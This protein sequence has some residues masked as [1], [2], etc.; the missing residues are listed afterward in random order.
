MAVRDCIRKL[1]AAGYKVSDRDKRLLEQWVRDGLS[2]TQAVNRMLAMAE[3]DV[4]DIASRARDRGAE[5]RK[6]P[7]VLGEIREYRE[8]Q[9]KQ[10]RKD[11]AAVQKESREL[12]IQYGDIQWIK[13]TVKH[14]TPLN[15]D[16]ERGAPIVGAGPFEGMD[17]P[18]DLNDDLALQNRLS[19]M[20]FANPDMWTKGQMAGGL[21]RGNSPR[22]L[23]NNFRKMEEQQRKIRDRL[24][25]LRPQ[26]AA[27]VD[28]IDEMTGQRPN[29]FYQSTDLGFYSA[30]EVAVRTMPMPKGDAKTV[31]GW[32]QKQPGVTADEITWLQI[33]EYL[34][35]MENV[36]REELLDYVRANGVVVEEIQQGGGQQIQPSLDAQPA[37]YDFAAE[38]WEV[39]FDDVMDGRIEIWDVTE[40]E[41]GHVF[42]VLVDH[43]AGN[44]AVRNEQDGEFLPIDAPIN[45][46]DFDDAMAAIEKHYLGL[47]PAGTFDAPASINEDQ[48]L[49]GGRN[50]REII[51]KLPEV[52]EAQI[53]YTG[54]FKGAGMGSAELRN[55]VVQKALSRKIEMRLVEASDG[56]ER[57][58]FNGLLEK[59]VDWFMRAMGDYGLRFEFKREYSM[60]DAEVNPVGMQQNYDFSHFDYPN[61]MGWARVKDRIG[62]NGEKILFIEE[63]QSDL[64]QRGRKR[65]YREGIPPAP[66]FVVGQDEFQWIALD[67]K[68]GEQIY[69]GTNQS[70]QP[71]KMSVGKGAVADQF[72]AE[73]YLQRLIHGKHKEMVDAQIDAVPDAPFKN[74]KWVDLVLKRM[75]RLAAEQGYD[76]VAWTTGETQ[77]IRNSLATYADEV[78]YNW[79][80]E[81]LK[82]YSKDSEGRI[83]LNFSETVPRAKL[84]TYVGSEMAQMLETEQR[85]RFE[86]NL[87]RGTIQVMTGREYLEQTGGMIRFPE[88]DKGEPAAADIGQQLWGDPARPFL[89]A[90][91]VVQH[92]D[93]IQRNQ[94]MHDLMVFA[95][96]D[97]A[98]REAEHHFNYQYPVTLTGDDMQVKGWP[99][100]NFYDKTVP[101]QLRKIVKKLDRD[102]KVRL[103]GQ[104]VR[105][106][107]GEPFRLDTVLDHAR[108]KNTNGQWSRTTTKVPQYYILDRDGRRRAGPF[109]TSDVA[110]AKLDEYNGE[111]EI[112]HV[113]DLTNKI[114]NNVMNGQQLFQGKRGSITFN[115]AR[116][117]VIRLYESHNLST[118]IH[119]AGHLYLEIMG[120][121]ASRADS[122][123]QIK[124]DWQTI[125][126]YLGVDSYHEIT[127]EHHEKWAESFE[128]YTMEGKAPSIKLRDAFNAFRS[129]LLNVYRTIRGGPK[130]QVLTP[131]IRGVM[132]RM[133]ASDEEIAI[134]E[135]HQEYASLF[136]TQEESG[137]SPEAYAVYRNELVRAHNEGVEKEHQTVLQALKR[138]SMAWWKHEREKVRAE[139]E[140]EAHEMRVYKALFMLQRG[141]QPD[142]SAPTMSPFKINKQS[143]LDLLGPDQT[144]LNQLP[145]PWVYAAK[146]GVDV[147]EAARIFGYRDA[148]AM[149]NELASAPKMTDWIEAE[150]DVRMR[151]RYPD[152][153]HDGTLSETALKAVHN[154]RRANVLMTELRQ[155]RALQRRDR[156]IVR[157]TERRIAREER[158]AK[159]ANRGILPKRAELAAIK[160]GAKEAIG[161]RR[162]REVKPHIYLAA[163]RKAA[164]QAFEAATRK[165]WEAAYNFKRQQIINHEMYRAAV[166]AE[167]E[168]T[169][170]RNYLAKFEKPRKRQ[171]MGKAG[172]LDQIDAVLEGVDLRKKS[173]SQVDREERLKD[174]RDMVEDGRMIVTPETLAK[175]VDETVNWQQLTVEEMRGLRDVVK[176]L[177]HMAKQAEMNNY[178]VNGETLNLDDVA[179]ELEAS[180]LENNTEIALHGGHKTKKQ[181]V[182]KAKDQAITNWL[183]PSSI[184]RVL[185]KAGFGA[186]SRYIIVPLRRAYS[187]RLIPAL[188]KAQEDVSGIYLKHYSTK[189]LAK[190]HKKNITIESQGV[191]YSK[192][193]AIAVALNWGNEGN[194]RAL[195]GGVLDNGQLAYPEP[196]AR[197]LLAQLSE[198]DWAFVQDVWD[199]I[200]TYWK[201]LSE[202]EQ[203][204]RGIAPSKVEGQPFQIRTADGKQITVRGGYYPL[205]YD[206]EL[207]DR[208]KQDSLED[209]YKKLGT[210][211]YVSAS[212]R[213]G[214]THERTRQQGLVVRLDLNVID[215][216][217]REII[218]DIAIGDEVNFVKRILNDRRFRSA[219]KRTGNNEAL[220]SLNLWLTDAAVGE[221]PAQNIYQKGA[222]WIRGGF[223]KSRLG[224]NLLVT[225]LQWT[226]F[227]QSIAFVGTKGMMMG[228]GKF[229]QN[230]AKWW[231][232]VSESSDFIRTRYDVGAWHKDVQDVDA[233]LN[234]WFG[235]APTIAKETMTR[236]SYGLFLPIKYAQKVVDVITWLGAYEKARN[237]D[238]E[239]HQQSVLMADAAVEGAQTSGFFTDRSNIERGTLSENTRQAEYIRIWTTLIGYMLAKGNIAYEKTKNTNF[240]KPSQ[241]LYWSMDMILLFTVEGI[242]SYLLYGRLPEED[243][244]GDE[245][246]RWAK[247]TAAATADSIVSGI[248]FVREIPSQRYGSGSTPIGAFAKDL[249]NVWVQAEQGEAD[250]AL[251]KALVNAVGTATHLPSSQTNRVLDAI[252]D[253]D[254]TELLEYITGPKDD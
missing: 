21:L 173:L 40:R 189:D 53:L 222:R 48:T 199:Y 100:R 168:M 4:V 198:K 253:E 88:M 45:K 197:Q 226:G 103:N 124:D 143:L 24:R 43:D 59:D 154:E 31:L 215:I 74:N 151:Q 169:K 110:Q 42:E 216:H 157:A 127:R 68:T 206:H 210:G 14:W 241:I 87:E 81:E 89:D 128:A 83:G 218:R 211:V 95:D 80:K 202:A 237:V 147:N 242:A 224:L 223:T 137:M 186:V 179:V 18:V 75:V 51:L 238:G 221:M 99:M 126:D 20:L 181:G 72:E 164:R 8:G 34:D 109:D 214:A 86:N 38:K 16:T 65:G 252:W 114:R 52:Q 140:T 203:R 117:G 182:V 145:R 125:L 47:D 131:E 93:T 165:D 5:I 1:E 49:G 70:G 195:L 62:P 13:D 23:F 240:R 234:A 146:G 27:L 35:L 236:I 185:D 56:Y 76:Q 33:P 119:E 229:M 44:V 205:M 160:A 217:L 132:D 251:R 29:Q 10:L 227:F 200:D 66:N 178:L 17:P 69:Y 177:E 150:T 176:Q 115:N 112:V 153:L 108:Y 25:E 163:E 136:M 249:F 204:R 58:M 134:A 50:Y 120:S 230:P 101:Q 11:L 148:H 26:E 118:F 90:Y 28:Q 248:P 82:V 84:A 36:T 155:L 250:E 73:V 208:V 60:T 209:I 67:P 166:R 94:A 19:A 113:M 111:Q 12:D 30:V 91:V 139:V 98:M 239:N 213:A 194:R 247:W 78:Q 121:L 123:Q 92:G 159:A 174:L 183:R 190:L 196:V 219:M 107:D 220:K 105:T 9:L 233:H 244:E 71:S 191:T 152:P 39:D 228:V 106:K 97:K 172:F 245:L 235:A 46:Q 162:V 116:Q 243:D 158:Q 231:N 138:E 96:K 212:T 102:A 77:V 122:P 142:G 3:F 161:R 55:A 6:R 85:K 54:E 79:V 207:S 170:A 180:V 64:H 167:A 135:N 41:T 184:A 201:D 130:A 144:F 61:I 141:T 254:D 193:D 171:Q 7:D 63:I 188:H 175:I 15:P 156:G 57:W 149:M 187:E 104:Q 37:P 32:L 246:K 22:E 129:W 133:L 2:D 232:Y 225:A 192:A